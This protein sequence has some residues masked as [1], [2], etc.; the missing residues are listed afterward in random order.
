M[1][2]VARE[3]D[4]RFRHEGSA[5]AV[6]PAATNEPTR[7]VCQSCFRISGLVN[8]CGSIGSMWP[9]MDLQGVRKLGLWRVLVVVDRVDAVLTQRRFVPCI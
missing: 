2:T 7:T 3:V 5:H 6:L 4:E 8:L 9:E 1:A